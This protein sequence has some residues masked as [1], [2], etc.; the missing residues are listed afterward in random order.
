ML[1]LSL[2]LFHWWMR[3][4][5]RILVLI[6]PKTWTGPNWIEADIRDT[7][8]VH[9]FGCYTR[10][11]LSHVIK[12]FMIVTAVSNQRYKDSLNMT[13][14]KVLL[15]SLHRQTATCFCHMLGQRSNY[16]ANNWIFVTNSQHLRII[17]ICTAKIWQSSCKKWNIFL[18]KIFCFQKFDV[19]CTWIIKQ[20]QISLCMILYNIYY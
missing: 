17:E 12:A 1:P 4:Y 20:L 7:G 6:Y 3:W 18:F 19:F 5:E 11:H 9:V 13:Q 2:L 16:K 8:Q 10:I 15:S 14:L